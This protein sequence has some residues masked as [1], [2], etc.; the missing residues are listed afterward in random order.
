M[1]KAIFLLLY[2]LILKQQHQQFVVPYV[3][4]VAFHPAL[5][6]N[7]IIIQ[8]S[9]AH[10]LEQSTS[11]NYFSEDQ[12]KFIVVQVIRQLKDIAIDVSKRKCKNTM[13]Q[14]F[15]IEIPLVKKTLLDWFNK[16]YRTQYL[17]INAFLKMQYER[18][19][20]V[21]WRDH[22]CVLCKMPLRVEPTNFKT[23]DDQMTYGDFVICFEH[24]FIGNIFT[25]R[26]KS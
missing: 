22:K 21:N 5:S 19:N 24:K 12:M 11:L 14:M 8:R 26:I 4:I 25:S 1:Q 2:T 6:V 23:P 17:E 9:Y 3:L 7:R 10:S 20:P 18:N 13:G 16:K 15:C